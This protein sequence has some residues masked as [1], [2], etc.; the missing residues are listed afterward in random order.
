M[1]SWAFAQRAPKSCPRCALT[2]DAAADGHPSNHPPAAASSLLHDHIHPSTYVLATPQ[3]TLRAP[4]STNA[5]PRLSHH[6]TPPSPSPTLLDMPALATASEMHML[7]K[8]Q[9]GYC[10]DAFGRIYRCNRGLGTG[11][12]AGVGVAIAVFVI[13]L[14]LMLACCARRRRRSQGYVFRPNTTTTGPAPGFAPGGQGNMYAGGAPQQGQFYGNQAYPQQGFGQGNYG[15][16]GGAPYQGTPNGGAFSYPPPNDANY[17]A[18]EGPP[19]SSGQY[20]APNAPPPS[21]QPPGAN[22]EV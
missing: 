3:A 15:P 1:R 14:I 13:F 17:K 19:P 9:S 6:S 12:R 10:R 21:Y 16:Q 18:P 11:G 2:L 22:K 8:R 5:L 7:E 4:S 20:A